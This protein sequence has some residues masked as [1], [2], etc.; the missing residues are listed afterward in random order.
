MGIGTSGPNAKLDIRTS[1]TSISDPGAGYI[2]IGTTSTTAGTAGSGAIR[3]STSGGGVLEYSNGTAWNTLTSTVTKSTVIAKNLSGQSI[4]DQTATNVTNWTGIVD[5][6]NNFDESTGIFTA[7]RSGNYVFSF[8]Y[9]FTSSNFGST[10]SVIEA[11][12]SCS[13]S[14]KL[15]RQ[16]LAAPVSVNSQRS[17]S[18]ITFVVDLIAGE[19]LR[20]MIWHNTG[21][22]RSLETDGTGTGFINI[23][24]V[25]L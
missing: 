16:L 4:A 11:W 21:V 7:P 2:G 6:N 1:P 9:A 18:M 5:N 13:V 20:P 15:R 17:G 14:A 8:S 19:T 3:Y 10:P 22:A 24:I 25:E 23:S 12:M